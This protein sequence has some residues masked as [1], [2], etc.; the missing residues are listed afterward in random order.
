[1]FSLK[2][3]EKILER[4]LAYFIF[5]HCFG[6]LDEEDFVSSLGFSL[7]CERLLASVIKTENADNFEDIV[8]LARTVSEEIEYSDE[9]TEAIKLEFMF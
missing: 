8:R 3:T 1:M 7:F 2:G 9:N 6:A 4:A 5:R